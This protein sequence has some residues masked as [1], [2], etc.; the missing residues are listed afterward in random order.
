MPNYN[1]KALRIQAYDLGAGSGNTVSYTFLPTATPCATGITSDYQGGPKINTVS[2]Y[3]GEAVTWFANPNVASG[4]QLTA[5]G[6]MLIRNRCK[7]WLTLNALMT[8]GGLPNTAV[9]IPVAP[10]GEHWLALN[11][12]NITS[13]DGGNYF[14][15]TQP[16]PTSNTRLSLD[17]VVFS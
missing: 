2:F 17:F 11:T 16:I 9:K 10:T 3:S 12:T 15:S 6:D 14:D 5:V 8:T 13:V 4:Q 7:F 1:L